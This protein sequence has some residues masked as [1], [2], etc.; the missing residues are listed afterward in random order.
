MPL[1]KSKIFR[2]W[3]FDDNALDWNRERHTFT[4]RG[5]LFSIGTCKGEENNVLDDHEKILVLSQERRECASD[6]Q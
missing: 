1:Y 5:N 3:D 4:L 2:S 6:G